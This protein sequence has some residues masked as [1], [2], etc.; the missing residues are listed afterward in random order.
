MPSKAYLVDLSSQ[1]DYT[2]RHIKRRRQHN[3]GEACV[4]VAVDAGSMVVCDG[5][6]AGS[7]GS[8]ACEE[9][10]CSSTGTGGGGVGSG[11][12]DLDFRDRK[13]PLNL[14]GISVQG[15][16]TLQLDE[17]AIYLRKGTRTFVLRPCTSNERRYSSDCLD[18]STNSTS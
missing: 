2:T 12:C 3:A 9:D 17:F 7:C 18:R 13:R 8:T 10:P 15:F 5:R 16:A 6:T 14:E 11:D 1:R 4:F